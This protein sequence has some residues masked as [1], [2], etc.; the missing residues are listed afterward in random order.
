MT[1]KVRWTRQEAGCGSMVLADGNLIVLTE[2]GDLLLVEA[3]PK[4]YRERAK[5]SLL[6]GPCRAQPA[7]ANGRLY[8]RDR[9]KLY[10]WDLKK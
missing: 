7:L 9:G 1:G 2:D 4:E 8:A 5:A 6:H 10:C 3:T